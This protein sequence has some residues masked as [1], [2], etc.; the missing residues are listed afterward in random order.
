MANYIDVDPFARS[1]SASSASSQSFSAL[2][3]ASPPVTAAASSSSTPAAVAV[4]S[5]LERLAGATP[6]TSEAVMRAVQTE[7][8]VNRAQLRIAEKIGEGFF[9]SVHR[10]MLRDRVVAVKR[11]R[12]AQYR[13][14]G[15]FELVAK[16]CAAMTLL[17]HEF[18]VEFIGI[19]E[20]GPREF[21]IVTQ[22][23]GGGTVR[24]RIVR[25]P[26]HITD[27]FRIRVVTCV[28]KAM[29]Y[30]H[31]FKPRAMI[32]RDLTTSN[33][34]LDEGTTGV[35]YVCDLGLSRVKADASR[36]MT[37]AVG[38][39]AFMAPELFR[40]EQYDE[41]CDIYSFAIVL[42][43]LVTMNSDICAGQTPHLWASQVAVDHRRP[44]LAGVPQRYVDLLVRCW[45]PLPADRPPFSEI[46]RYIGD[47]LVPQVRA[48]SSM[49]AARTQSSI[50]SA[51]IALGG[52]YVDPDVDSATQSSEA[53]T[54]DLDSAVDSSGT[55]AFVRKYVG[56]T[57][58]VCGVFADDHS[59][60]LLSCSTDQ[61]V[62]VWSLARTG[63]TECRHTITGHA[64]YVFAVA[65]A[66]V[67]QVPMMF[68]A[69]R[70]TTIR[71]LDSSGSLMSVLSGGH[72][73]GVRD[74]QLQDATLASASE[75][76]TVGIW[77]LTSGTQLGRLRGHTGVAYS[78]AFLPGSAF[79]VLSSADD[80]TVKAWD[81]RTGGCVTTFAEHRGGVQRVRVGGECDIFS[82]GKDGLALRFDARHPLA[83]VVQYRGHRDTVF[84]ID[85]PNAVHL[86]SCGADGNVNRFDLDSG[87]LLQD[88]KPHNAGVLAIRALHGGN[89]LVTGGMDKTVCVTRFS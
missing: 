86:F 11:I 76:H 1:A 4:V 70:D 59:D 15:E 50:P 89:V 39:L 42:W 66:V 58:F 40:G 13:N 27:A 29:Q 10:G 5:F 36:S 78:C 82:C 14:D 85:V 67:R 35:A 24:E 44:S 56:H 87:Q 60:T 73:G 22:F 52:A 38:S 53:A 74:I 2:L 28:A 18:I 72:E 21:L 49:T 55:S 75:D 69:S 37:A 31:A 83:S 16:E 81:T 34:L 12:R 8:R 6:P 84:D 64:G 48:R 63:S 19:A 68:T 43:E 23:I 57:G 45:A 79:I 7:K 9:G 25:S 61:T 54:V 80:S 26:G 46:L 77:D 62:R 88:T 20:E 71:V 47:V 65:A 30:M 51:S 33:I 32:H 41:K 3:A 17:N